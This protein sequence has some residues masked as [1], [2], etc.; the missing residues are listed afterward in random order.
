MSSPTSRGPGPRSPGALGEGGGG[1]GGGTPWPGPIPPPPKNICLIFF[2]L[3][4]ICFTFSFGRHDYLCFLSLTYLICMCV[5]FLF[6][7]IMFVHFL[8]MSNKKI[9]DNYVKKEND[10]FFDQINNLITNILFGEGDGRRGYRSGHYIPKTPWT[11]Q[12]G[13]LSP[14]YRP[15][16]NSQ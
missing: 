5:C 6:V 2:V 15:S 4:F 7:I 1:G 13:A 10:L 14:P 8:I 3:V 9:K 11:N 12:P 16:R